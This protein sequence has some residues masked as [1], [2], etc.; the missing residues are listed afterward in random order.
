MNS[1]GN[2]TVILGV[3]PENVPKGRRTSWTTGASSDAQILRDLFDAVCGAAREL[4]LYGGDCRDAAAE[5]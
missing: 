1:A 4:R 2:L 5:P 3:S